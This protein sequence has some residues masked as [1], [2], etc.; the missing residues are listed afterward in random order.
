MFD[1]RF[2]VSK[3]KCWDLAKYA[4]QGVFT[5]VVYEGYRIGFDG[6]WIMN[7]KERLLWLPLDY[8]TKASTVSGSQVALGT[9]S[10][11]L[12]S[13]LL[14]QISTGSLK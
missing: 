13:L 12:D 14:M 8:R 3:I 10:R 1:R 2:G 9:I 4:C 7:G 6:R 11:Q 5:D